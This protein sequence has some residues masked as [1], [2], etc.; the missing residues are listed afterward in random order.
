MCAG[1]AVLPQPDGPA[2]EL[3]ILRQLLVHLPQPPPELA[4]RQPLVLGSGCRCTRL[5][6]VR[7]VL[8]SLAHASQCRGDGQD[9]GHAAE[10][11]VAGTQP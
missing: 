7:Q 3:V 1:R 6:P 4:Q 10:H 8:P 9:V 5:Y 2:D 11:E